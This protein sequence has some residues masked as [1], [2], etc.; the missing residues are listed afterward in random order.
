MNKFMRMSLGILDLAHYL[1]LYRKRLFTGTVPAN[2]NYVTGTVPA[3]KS[4]VTGTVGGGREGGGR[5]GAGGGG[6]GWERVRGGAFHR[7]C[8]L[9][10]WGRQ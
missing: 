8:S 5:E 3:N 9:S 2:K 10:G 1:Y 7:F 4:Y 6:R